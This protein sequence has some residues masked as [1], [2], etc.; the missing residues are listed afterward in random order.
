MY[1]KNFIKN[2]NVKH[3]KIGPEKIQEIFNGIT[4][5]GTFLP[6]SV[7]EED[8][9]ASFI[10]FVTKG[11]EIVIDGDK[12][13]VTF[14][15]IQ[16]WA[17]FSKTWQFSDKFKDIKLPF[18]SV[19]RRPDIQVGTN[20]AGLW[21][22]PGNR[23]YTYMKVPTW[24]GNIKGIDTYKIPQPTAIDVTYEVRLFCGKMRDLNKLH[25]KVQQ[26]FQSRQHYIEA[27]G[28]PMP[29]ILE[30]VG[31]ESNI[32][33]FENRRFYIQQ[34]EMKLMGYIL[35][36]DD[37]EIVP[38]INRAIV[39]TELER[40]VVKAKFKVNINKQNNLINYNFLFLPNAESTFSFISDFD[41]K[42]TELLNIDGITSISIS[43]NGLPV[44]TGL[45]LS[46][47]IIISAGDT[48]KITVVKSFIGTGKFQLFG[49]LI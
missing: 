47:P 18:I 1:P 14:M 13:P 30:N 28:H 46:S 12:V 23:T 35:D 40:E 41:I 48:I 6:K 7:L 16:R 36:S 22:I 25:R 39:L 15:T 4:D 3:K 17:E 8:L 37:F 26:T 49:N 10:D 38:T 44:F 31:D 21:N 34:F 45:I 33:D 43:I 29:V 20:Q 2:I 42:F 11:L 5:H 27:N 9:D 24:N 19:I 32:D